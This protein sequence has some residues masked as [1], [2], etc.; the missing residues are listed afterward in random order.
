MKQ[1]DVQLELL[2]PTCISQQPTAPG[3]PIE[4]R[5]YITGTVLRGGL[6]TQWLCGRCYG[7]LNVTEKQQ[8]RQF[9]LSEQIV[10]QNGWPYDNNKQTWVVPS[11]AWTNKQNSGW[12][13]D[14][15]G[16][17]RDVLFALLRGEDTSS[18]KWEGW[19]RLNQDF[20][21]SQ[22]N[23]WQ[24]AE[25]SRRLIMRT[26]LNRNNREQLAPTTRGVG[27]EGQLYSIEALEAGQRYRAVISGPEAL[28][29]AFQQVFPGFELDLT[30][31]QGRSRG[32][33]QVRAKLN[34]SDE[35]EDRD[36]T[37]L[38]N[39]AEEF[40]RCVGADATTIYLPVTLESDTILRDSY[41]LP[42]SSAN[43]E[44]TLWRY[45][46]PTDAIRTMRLH[47]VVQSTRWSSGWDELRRVPRPAQLTVQMGAV[48]VFAVSIAAAP[49]AITWWL[50]AER[51]GIGE[52]CSE[53]FGRVRLLHE[54]HKKE[55]NHE[56]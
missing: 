7:D 42:C 46:P 6:A 15:K 2:S 10:F 23:V 41:L 47:R 53:G 19:D 16:G 44:E 33:G 13:G 9:F 51:H 3:Q 21:F 31:G 40:S 49:A 35:R 36:P 28:I 11:T 56:R 20:V 37:Q 54:F 17:V 29:E 38:L 43:P 39:Y 32:M 14:R 55:E 8:F 52:R 27:A 45:L 24:K 5:P 4:T 26:A 22:H 50:E 25:I 30:F 12:C 18:G 48:W 1:I 34:S